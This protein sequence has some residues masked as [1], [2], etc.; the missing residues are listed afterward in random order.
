MLLKVD[1]SC[2]EGDNVLVANTELNDKFVTMA[3]TYILECSDEQCTTIFHPVNSSLVHNWDELSSF[4]KS[5]MKTACEFF[6]SRR[7]CEVTTVTKFTNLIQVQGVTIYSDIIESK[8]PICFPPQCSESEVNVVHPHPAN[9]NHDDADPAL[10]CEVLSYSVNCPSRPISSGSCAANVLSDGHLFNTLQD[11]FKASID[12]NCLNALNTGENNDICALGVD[13]VEVDS[14]TSSDGFES[15]PSYVDYKDFCA[16]AG[17]QY[18]LVD[19]EGS[20]PTTADFFDPDLEFGDK[21]NISVR[22][23]ASNFPLCLPF[24]CSNDDLKILAEEHYLRNI[25]STGG[26]N[27][28][29]SSTPCTANILNVECQ[30]VAP[31]SAPTKSLFTPSTTISP[32]ETF[33]VDEFP[34]QTPTFD[35]FFS[36]SNAP[37]STSSQ[38]PSL[39]L[40]SSPSNAPSTTSSQIPSL[41]LSSSPSNPPSTTPS[42]LASMAPSSQSMKPVNMNITSSNIIPICTKSMIQSYLSQLIQKAILLGDVI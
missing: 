41:L 19:M 10:N 25:V 20:F 18:C 36:P 29:H 1:D 26:A 7:V 35:S 33:F 34:S 12:L 31:S 27:C 9:C 22:A 15:N 37:S 38:I 13:T 40:S 42:H 24:S 5:T 23:K 21:I 8:K 16:S 2:R 28:A 39:L 11:I 4:T 17:G 6:S 30:V 3:E 14:E 32:S